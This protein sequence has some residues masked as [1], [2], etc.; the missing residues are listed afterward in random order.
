[1]QLLSNDEGVEDFF[2]TDEELIDIRDEMDDMLDKYPDTVISSRYYHEIITTGKMLNRTFGWE[3]CPSVT[4][5]IDHR[6][7]KPKHLIGLSAG[8]RI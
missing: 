4:E 3:E 2:W 5:P 1:M 7:P 8:R 6:D